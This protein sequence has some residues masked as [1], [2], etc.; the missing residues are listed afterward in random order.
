MTLVNL[1]H[2]ENNCNNSTN[3]Y[4]IINE[5]MFEIYFADIQ[6][7]TLHHCTSLVLILQEN[8]TD[9]NLPNIN[10]VSFSYM[11]HAM[12]LYRFSEIAHP[13]SQIYILTC[14]L[15]FLKEVF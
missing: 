2:N 8:S 1:F 12:K 15:D 4:K 9:M 5:V 6:I 11:A 10:D 3:S 14:F 7:T 13:L